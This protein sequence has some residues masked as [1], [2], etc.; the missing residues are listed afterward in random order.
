MKKTAGM[1]IPV[2][3]IVLGICGCATGNGGGV[4]SD[5]SK[6]EAASKEDAAEN[7]YI[8]V[9]KAQLVAERGEEE[10]GNGK[11]SCFLGEGKAYRFIDYYLEPWNESYTEIVTADSQEALHSWKSPFG[12]PGYGKTGYI[13]GA[14]HIAGSD[15]FVTLSFQYPESEGEE[16][17]YSIEKRSA[18]G[19]IVDSI[20][21]D[22]LS[23]S[24]F[25]EV[26]E[27]IAVDRDGY[28]HMAGAPDVDSRMDYQVVSP[29]GELLHTKSF[30]QYRF[31]RLITLPDGRIACDS[32]EHKGGDQY[33]HL[34]E[35]IDTRTGE[36]DLLFEYDECSEDGK[37]SIQAINVFDE[38]RLIYSTA[39]GVFLCDY[40]FRERNRLCTWANQG[41]A[42]PMVVQ[43][44]AA[45]DGSISVLLMYRR[46]LFFLI[47]EPVPDDVFEIE[48]ATS[49]GGTIYYEAVAKFNRRYPQYNIV[50]REDYDRTALLTRLIAGDGPV[51]IGSD[52]VPFEEQKKLWEP[53]DTVYEESGILDS[54]NPAAVS[55]ASID[56]S[57]YGIVSD[58][59][60]STLATGAAEEDW[61][62]D[63]F[64]KCVENGGELQYIVDN[65]LGGSNVW[66]ALS[67]FDNG[68]EDSFYLNA[69]GEPEFDTQEFR[70]VLNLI[71]TYGPDNASVPFVE[72]LRERR[73]LCNNIHIFHPQ[74]LYFYR[75]AYGEGVKLAGFPHADGARHRLRSYHILAMRKTASETEKEIAAEFMKM[76]LSYDTQLAMSKDD[77]FQL[78]VRTDVLNEQ[79]DSIVE[80][81][82]LSAPCFDGV[83]YLEEPDSE[84]IRKELLEL[85]EKSAPWSE[86]SDSYKDILSEE[87]HEYFSGKIT[88][89]MLI[90]HLNNRVGLYFKERN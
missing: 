25:S 1:L 75:E 12:E 50:I 54:L 13:V 34:V 45:Q 18:N 31:V 21:L 4:F 56:G 2:L 11:S 15:G 17:R 85:I 22:Y 9:V 74:D 37:E 83:F 30:V 36:E 87:F 81:T 14:G 52:L 53:L 67:L 64:V 69:D 77:N 60:I 7:S 68:P 33:H 66:I 40:S 3:V 72:G 86:N 84:G 8:S 57:L 27:T 6:K 78:S 61:D 48:L 62:Y 24:E 55:L 5:S 47:L 20:E 39:N 59:F 19:D 79:I 76:L 35:W 90:N 51:L 88:E 71:D 44:S 46:S 10:V 65:A 43:I 26:A 73:V 63:T 28:L 82:R 70:K 58:F 29:E 23:S 41:F 89:D 16:F 80:G 32:R 38:E 49:Y 42:N